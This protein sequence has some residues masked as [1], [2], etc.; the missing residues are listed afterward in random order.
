MGSPLLHG[1]TKHVYNSTQERVQ[2]RVISILCCVI[3]CYVVLFN[4]VLRYVILCYVVLRH[5]IPCRVVLSCLVSCDIVFVLCDVVL[6]DV[7][8]SVR[9]REKPKGPQTE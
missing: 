8:S 1:P 3:L 5:V 9:K 4:I 7:V 6:C 2:K